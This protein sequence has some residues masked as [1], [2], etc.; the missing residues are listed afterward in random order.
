MECPHCH[1]P[2]DPGAAFC[3]NC[4]QPLK[5][6]AVLT[7]A[8]PAYAITAPI[9][10]K[11]E[12]KALL[13]VLFGAAG[14]IGAVFIVIFGL[15]LGLAGL[16]MGTM[17]RHTPKRLLSTA[18]L[19]LS[20]VSIAA[21]LG[22]WAYT[23]NHTK[24]ANHIAAATPSPAIV[25]RASDLSTPCYSAGFAENLQ[26]SRAQNSCN[27]QVY[28]GASFAQS[29]EVYKIYA[30]QSQVKTAAGFDV[31]AKKALESD[32]QANL[33]GFVIESEQAGNFAGS[34][35]YSLVALDRANNVAV[36]ESVVYHQSPT[37][38][39]TFIL[40]HGNNGGSADLQILE[41]QWQWK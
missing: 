14:I 22:V 21:G 40:L 24:H 9:S 7:T 27:V 31:L 16:V 30:S 11:G 3:G 41:S 35:S 34:P 25:T 36:I 6:A 28:N 26:V 37:G 13:S 39:N 29:S 15:G 5:T 38:D 33:K 18:G 12:N 4:G 23:V 32:V 17:S 10:H 2:T 19:V 20:S 8:A 1:E